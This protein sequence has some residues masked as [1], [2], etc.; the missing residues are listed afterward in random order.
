MEKGIGP[1]MINENYSHQTHGDEMETERQNERPEDRIFGTT[2][3]WS[4]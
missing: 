4:Y 2:F 3:H 1:V